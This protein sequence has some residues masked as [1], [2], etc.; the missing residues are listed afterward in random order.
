MKMIVSIKIQTWWLFGRAFILGKSLKCNLQF[1]TNFTVDGN[2]QNY[3]SSV[4]FRV[5]YIN[6]EVNVNFCNY[7][8]NCFIGLSFSV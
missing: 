8:K 4:N 2:R 5:H 7:R 6:E 3:V 1:V